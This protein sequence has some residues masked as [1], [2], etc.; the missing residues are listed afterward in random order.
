LGKLSINA[1]ASGTAVI[2][3]Y[4]M[5]GKRLTTEKA[6]VVKGVNLR[7]VDLG[8]YSKGIFHVEIMVDGEKRLVKVM[9]Q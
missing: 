7:T 3:I 6:G 4:D 8:K 2:N 9:V 1:K 5:S